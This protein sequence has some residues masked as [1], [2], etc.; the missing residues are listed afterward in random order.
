L[1]AGQQP[2][3]A[4]DMAQ[5]NNPLASFTAFNVHNSLKTLEIL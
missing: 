4:D 2:A 3:R 1:P 5:A